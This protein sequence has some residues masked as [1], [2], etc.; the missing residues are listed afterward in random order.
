[1]SVR[2]SHVRPMD[3]HSQEEGGG[4]KEDISGSDRRRGWVGCS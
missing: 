2:M 3:V 1:M 4:K